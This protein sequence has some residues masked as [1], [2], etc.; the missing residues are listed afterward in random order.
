[1]GLQ[2]NTTTLKAS[3]QEIGAENATKPSDWSAEK[4]CTGASDEFQRGRAGRNRADGSFTPTEI[5]DL[6]H[7]IFG[8]HT[9]ACEGGR[10]MQDT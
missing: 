7:D 8:G 6:F 10:G 3:K 4:R 9:I 2:L 1:M 5:A